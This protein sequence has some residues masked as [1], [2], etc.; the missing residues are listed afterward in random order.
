VFRLFSCLIGWIDLFRFNCL[1]GRLIGW[2]GLFGFGWT[3]F[4]HLFGWLVD[5][6]VG[7]VSFDLSVCLASRWVGWIYSVWFDCS[8]YLAR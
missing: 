7:L 5:Y 4:F 8:I 6:I 3:G 1:F 2:L